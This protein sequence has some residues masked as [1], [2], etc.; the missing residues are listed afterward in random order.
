[1][2]AK[3][4]ETV[5]STY[6]QSHVRLANDKVARDLDSH[7]LALLQSDIKN[8]RLS[9]IAAVTALINSPNE[10]FSARISRAT[11]ALN[12]LESEVVPKHADDTDTAEATA[13][14]VATFSRTCGV[15]SSEVID[16][17]L[18]RAIRKLLQAPPVKCSRKSLGTAH[19]AMFLKALAQTNNRLIL[20][21]VKIITAA[22]CELTR[23][24]IPAVRAAGVAALSAILE[25]CA[26]EVP[27]STPWSTQP[28]LEMAFST[29]TCELDVQLEPLFVPAFSGSSIPSSCVPAVVGSLAVI[30]NLLANT[31]TRLLILAPSSPQN[32]NIDI[33]GTKFA[34]CVRALMQA[35]SSAIRHAV[36]DLLP[37]L[38]AADPER[39]CSDGFLD[40]SYTFLASSAEESSVSPRERTNAVVALGRIAENVGEDLF[41]GYLDRA[42]RLSSVLLRKRAICDE[43]GAVSDTD[44]LR[45]KRTG[46]PIVPPSIA[47]DFVHTLAETSSIVWSLVRQ[48]YFVVNGCLLLFM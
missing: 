31:A 3:R 23:D 37:G 12:I 2:I 13:S 44:G 1:M 45:C 15:G 27:N 5:T 4:L 17:M 14:L 18:S 26:D 11:L 30:R 40:K 46:A 28:Y 29:I 19:S 41:S 10:T 25:S 43:T 39:F 47:L 20:D 24:R 38:A 7:L 42:L 6:W 33:Y 16:A 8:E 9:G 21:N 35:Q 34:D 22:L 48:E 36:A 32:G